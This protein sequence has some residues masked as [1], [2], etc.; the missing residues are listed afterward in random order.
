MNLYQINFSMG[1]GEVFRIQK[2]G[3]SREIEGNRKRIEMEIMM[4]P[5]K[6]VFIKEINFESAWEKRET[7]S[8]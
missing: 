7:L 3:P 2:D 8:R 1:K 4:K 5:T 6:A